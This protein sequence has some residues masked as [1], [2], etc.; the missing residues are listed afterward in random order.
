MDH[1]DI[2]HLP[3]FLPMLGMESRVSLVLGVYPSAAFS[4]SL[5]A[6]PWLVELVRDSL[7]PPP[8]TPH[9]T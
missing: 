3:P 9:L 5:G 4:D 2:G 1:G 8:A 6:I 7:P